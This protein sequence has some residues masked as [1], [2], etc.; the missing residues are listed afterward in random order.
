[1][2]DPLDVLRSPVS[3]VA[4]DPA[5]VTRLRARLVDAL[6]PDPEGTW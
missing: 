4:P 5:F 6:T 3:P 2:T 1:M